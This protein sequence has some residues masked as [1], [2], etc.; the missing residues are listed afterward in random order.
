MI[1]RTFNRRWVRALLS[2]GVPGAAV[3]GTSCIEDV[4]NSVIAGSLDF[5]ED[6]TITVL[7]SLIPV[8][9]ILPE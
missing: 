3:F 1:R 7:E 2:F 5:V 4:R 6:S 9:E 8:G